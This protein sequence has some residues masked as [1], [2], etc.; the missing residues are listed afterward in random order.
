MVQLNSKIPH[1]TYDHLD[2]NNISPR[3]YHPSTNGGVDRVN[4]TMAR[5]LAIVDTTKSTPTKQ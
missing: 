3:S 1:L 4:P 5:I 2:I